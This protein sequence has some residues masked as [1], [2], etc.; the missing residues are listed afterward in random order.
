MIADLISQ[1]RKLGQEPRTVM[2]KGKPTPFPLA[3]EVRG[4]GQYDQ[5]RFENDLG[6][7]TPPDLN[8]LWAEASS[9]R[10]FEDKTYGQWG[11]ILWS[12]D[13]VKVKTE[14]IVSER[15]KD[16][17]ERD[18]IVGEFLGDSDLLVLRSDPECADFGTV[19]VALA[20]DSREDWDKVADSL[21][22]FLRRFI[23]AS[24]EKFWEN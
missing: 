2:H 21:G 24:G 23:E 20:M 11:L 7:K 6:V 18:L 13:E 5:H 15:R 14:K 19:L 4:T 8:E 1:I 12:C 17:R 3:C 10:L 22:E 16:F 9:L